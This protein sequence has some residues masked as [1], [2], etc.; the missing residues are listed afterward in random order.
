MIAKVGH[1]IIINV[2]A[3]ILARLAEAIPC[4]INALCSSLETIRVTEIGH[5]LIVFVYAV[6]NCILIK[7][8]TLVVADIGTFSPLFIALLVSKV[9]D[10]RVVF[11]DTC[12]LAL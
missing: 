12:I 6:I 9:W 2:N 8:F 5:A 7:G 10:T 11:A 1:A 4:L 3:L